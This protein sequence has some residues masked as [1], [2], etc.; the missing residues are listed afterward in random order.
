M[1][2]LTT[3]STLTA[4]ALHSVFSFQA[5]AQALQN[6][7]CVRVT[8]SFM[9]D[10]PFLKVMNTDTKTLHLFPTINTKLFFTCDDY[11]NGKYLSIRNNLFLSKVQTCE[12]AIEYEKMSHWQ[13][14]VFGHKRGSMNNR[15]ILVVR[16][17]LGYKIL[18]M[19]FI[20]ILD[21]VLSNIELHN[22]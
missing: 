10:L 18:S 4:T 19:T 8:I 6:R 17:S 13:S 12:K 9:L 7:E 3:T 20:E 11:S 15:V 16:F 22:R 5:A 2:S 1:W 14:V 21:N